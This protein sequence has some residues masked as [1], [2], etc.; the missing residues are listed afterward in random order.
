MKGERRVYG[1]SKKDRLAPR[2]RWGGRTQSLSLGDQEIPDPLAGGR[3]YARQALARAWRHRGCSEA[4]Q[5]TPEARGE[6][7]H[8]IPRLWTAGQ[9]VDQRGQ[10][11]PDAG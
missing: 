9:R 1:S 5:F 7:R 6:N 4:R 8:G 3:V 11:R 2:V 10:Y